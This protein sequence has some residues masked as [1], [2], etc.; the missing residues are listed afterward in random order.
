MSLESILL[1]MN[2]EMGAEHS[3]IDMGSQSI[4]VGLFGSGFFVSIRKIPRSACH[5]LLQSH[6]VLEDN[7]FAS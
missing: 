3:R 1:R 7:E 6:A 2:I 5:I 4:L